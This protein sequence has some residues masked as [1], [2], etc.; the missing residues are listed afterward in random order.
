MIAMNRSLN[1]KIS[2]LLIIFGLFFGVI[3]VKADTVPEEF[4]LSAVKFNGVK[5]VSKKELANT[6]AAKVPPKWKFWKPKPTLN[7]TDLEEDLL[8]IKQFYQRKGYYRAT[9]DFAIVEKDAA[10]PSTI[11]VTF[12]VTEGPPVV[13]QSIKFITEKHIDDISDQDLQTLFPLKLGQI[14]VT[15]LY[16]DGKKKLTE[17][18]GNHGYP[19]ADIK[20]KVIVS[21]EKNVADITLNINPGRLH[22][23]GK[24]QITENKGYVKD[25]IIQ[26]A[27]EFKE[28][29]IYNADQINQS[30]RNLYNLDVFQVALIKPGKPVRDSDAVSMDVQLKPKKR[31]NV[32]LGVGYG[33]EDGVRLSGALTYRNPFGRAG[34]FSLNARRSDIIETI[35]GSYKQ[36]YI[37][38]AKTQ[39]QANGG[40]TREKLDSYNNR[41]IFAN[42]TFLRNFKNSWV[43]R[44]GY[45]LELNTLEEL[46]LTD[47]EEITKALAENEFLI[48]SARAGL[49]RNTVDNDLNPTKGSLVSASVEYASQGL[50][51]EL[52]FF[53]PAVE[54]KKFYSLPKSLVL[55]GRIRFETIQETED[56][57]DI[58]IFKRLFLGGTYTVRGYGFQKLGPLD[59]SGN[60]LGGQTSLLGNLEI[61]YPIFKNI[62]GV[63]FLDVGHVNEAAFTVDAEDVRFACGAGLRYNTIIGPIRLDVGYKINP[64]TFGDV[65][66]TTIPG[67]EDKEIE[68]R[69][70][71][72]F[73]IGQTF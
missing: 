69:W 31:R 8:R 18:Y 21:T 33:N 24:I 10:I 43:G 17:A 27:M 60:P 52:T 57:D 16:N 37:F 39:L 35:F 15:D 42:A 49:Y 61:R 32:K 50:G 3:S 66:D 44:I 11:A 1:R 72:H 5:H 19:F 2:C 25:V 71:I 7:R 28:G 58:P 6:L 48:S 30:Q 14:F 47:P 23:F 45:N 73:S 64:P 22:T 38:D 46:K 67:E 4:R 13:A 36:P 40:W 55:A 54:F 63:A 56:T 53:Q 12:T 65:T 20:G 34:S 70:K 29:E 51:S 9:A 26:R 59:A 62:S 41:Q 68:D